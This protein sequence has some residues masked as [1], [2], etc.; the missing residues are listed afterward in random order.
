[1]QSVAGTAFVRFVAPA[2][3][4]SVT[5]SS[6]TAIKDAARLRTRHADAAAPADSAPWVRGETFLFGTRTR[7]CL[8]TPKKA[9][10]SERRPCCESAVL[11]EASH[12][13]FGVPNERSTDR[14]IQL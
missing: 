10:A 3:S 5:A 11:D 13:T 12:G 9:A 8:V 14:R 1:M 6:R 7:T 2:A 4:A